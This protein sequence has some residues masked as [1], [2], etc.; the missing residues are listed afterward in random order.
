MKIVRPP[1]KLYVSIYQRQLSIT[2][3]KNIPIKNSTIILADHDIKQWNQT[4]QKLPTLILVGMDVED[5]VL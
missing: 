4:H 5:A 2:V 3:W 1:S